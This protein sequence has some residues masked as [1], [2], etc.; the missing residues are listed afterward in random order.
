M[1][2]TA[3]LNSRLEK[4]GATRC[5]VN[6]CHPVLVK[7]KM[8]EKKQEKDVGSFGKF[9]LGIFQIKSEWGAITPFYCAAN[10]EIEKM[11][12][13]GKYFV[14]YAQLAAPSKLALDLELIKKTT[15]WTRS[16]LQERFKKSWDYSQ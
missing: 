15:D 1:H 10:P 6:A 7:T 5:Y 4:K 9:L 8:A 2:Y 3:D 14:P 11:N 16:T 13:R 12:W